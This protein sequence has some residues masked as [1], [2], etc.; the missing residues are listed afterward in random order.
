MLVYVNLLIFLFIGVFLF[1]RGAHG[2][3]EFTKLNTREVSPLDF[4]SLRLMRGVGW[5]Y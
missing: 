1:M 5:K 4:M 2:L 3:P